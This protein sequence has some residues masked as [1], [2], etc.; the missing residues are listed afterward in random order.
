MTDKSLLSLK[1]AV[2]AS[3]LDDRAR[4]SNAVVLLGE[5]PTA[6]EPLATT[7]LSLS[8]ASSTGC[9][10]VCSESLCDSAEGDDGSEVVWGPSE[11][12]VVVAE[13][14]RVCEFSS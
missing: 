7:R 4:W 11:A 5:E 9:L 10:G 12:D 6:A 1:N 13:S 2:G 8:I 14:A 3:G